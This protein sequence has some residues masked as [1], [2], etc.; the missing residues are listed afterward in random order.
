MK[1]FYYRKKGEMAKECRK[2]QADAKNDTL[3]KPESANVAKTTE[4][5]LF[6]A[7]EESCSMATHDDVWI[8]N[9]GASRNM[10][11]HNEWYT[12]LRPMGDEYKLLVRNGVNF[13]VKEV[14]TISFKMKEGSTRELIDF[15]WVPDLARNLL[16]V[17]AITNRDLQVRFDKKEVVIMNNKNKIVARGVRRNN[18]YEILASMAQADEGTSRLWHERFGHLSMQTLSAM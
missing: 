13:H 9:N 8:I 4:V 2:K 11:N 6:I 14:G 3:K 17:A 7:V 18:I 5:E 10:T 15:L 1:F 16:F 12:S